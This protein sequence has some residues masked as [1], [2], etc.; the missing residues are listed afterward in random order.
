MD[1]QIYYALLVAG[2]ITARLKLEQDHKNTLKNNQ[3]K[4]KR[5]LPTKKDLW[6]IIILQ[7]KPPLKK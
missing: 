5:E 1:V 2:N 6:L 3:V 7:Q 4:I